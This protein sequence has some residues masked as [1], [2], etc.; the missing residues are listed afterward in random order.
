MEQEAREKSGR[1][2]LIESI[3]DVGGKAF[4]PGFSES[5]RQQAESEFN[6]LIQKYAS[7]SHVWRVI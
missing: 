4:N 3:I 6:D 2:R 1:Q 5:S 7:L